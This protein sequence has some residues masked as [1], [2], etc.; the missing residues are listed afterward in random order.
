MQVTGG[1]PRPSPKVFVIWRARFC[2]AARHRPET[3]VGR[4]SPRRAGP[5]LARAKSGTF[6]TWHEARNLLDFFRSTG[7]VPVAGTIDWLIRRP[8]KTLL[9]RARPGG[10]HD[11]IG[12][13]PPRSRSIT[14]SN[15]TSPARGE[16]RR[17]FPLACQSASAGTSPGRDGTKPAS[18]GSHR[19]TAFC[20][21]QSHPT[22]IAARHR[23][24][25]TGRRRGCF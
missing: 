13:S 17:G 19:K 7:L 4:H 10:K 21:G 18:S 24:K 5:A 15:G 25:E 3:M 8:K 6:G 12:Y 9:R 11:S 16:M 23:A 22:R 20:A 2:Q 1:S 14:R